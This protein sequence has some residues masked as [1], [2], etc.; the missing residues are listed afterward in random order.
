MYSVN[1]CL[2][3]ENKL[4]VKCLRLTTDVVR[5]KNDRFNIK[6]GTKQNLFYN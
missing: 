2:T 3:E 5:E 1:F 4:N 6:D